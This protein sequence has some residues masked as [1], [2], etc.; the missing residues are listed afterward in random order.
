MK[1][2]TKY[3]Q[4]APLKPQHFPYLTNRIKYGK[5]NQAPS[6]LDDS[7]FSTKYKRNVSNK[8]LAASC[9]MQEW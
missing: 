5:D 9:T 7:P 1:Q 3:N 2:L 8:L 6:P 4:D